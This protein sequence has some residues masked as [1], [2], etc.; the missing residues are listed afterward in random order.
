MKIIIN[1]WQ[2]NLSTDNSGLVVKSTEC[3]FTLQ[4]SNGWVIV[5]S[6]RSDLTVLCTRPCSFSSKICNKKVSFLLV[7]NKNK[8]APSN[9]TSLHSQSQHW[10]WRYTC[11]CCTRTKQQPKK[12]RKYLRAS[13][14]ANIPLVYSWGP[15]PTSSVGQVLTVTVHCRSADSMQTMTRLV[16]LNGLSVYK[17]V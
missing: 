5:G 9:K 15:K 2:N 8:L 14:P 17:V 1:T 6:L 3:C 12:I 10:F 16:S 11:T 13:L 7:Q 4:R